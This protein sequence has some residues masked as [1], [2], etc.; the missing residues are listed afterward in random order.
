ML[1]KLASLVMA[2]V[3]ILV[4]IVTVVADVDVLIVAWTP[5]L[6][7]F[8]CLSLRKLFLGVVTVAG[9]AIM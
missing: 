2:V 4:V 5:T 7:S 8:P 3:V 6:I 9:I 1:H